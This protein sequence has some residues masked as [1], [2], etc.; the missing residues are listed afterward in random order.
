[1]LL[2]QASRDARRELSDRFGLWARVTGTLSLSAE[3]LE[4]MRQ[5]GEEMGETLVGELLGSAAGAEQL[6]GAVSQ[7]LGD[8]LY[9]GTTGAALVFSATPLDPRQ[10]LRQ[11]EIRLRVP[12]D[13]DAR[14]LVEHSVGTQSVVL[15]GLFRAYLSALHYRLLAI[16]VEEPEVHLFPH[17]ARALVK[18]IRAL[19]VQTLVTT[20]STSVTDLA[21]PRDLLLLRRHGDRTV[22]CAV[23][24]GYLTDDEAKDIRR[25]VRAAGSGFV[26]A[27][28]VLFAEGASEELALPVLAEQLELDL[29]S[30]GVSL[31]TVD[32]SSFRAFAKLLHPQA[33]NI[34]HLMVCDNDQAVRQFVRDLANAGVLPPGVVLHDPQAG[35]AILEAAGYYWWTAGD[36]ESCLLAAG[37]GPLFRQAIAELY[38][39]K[40]LDQ[41]EQQL[42][43][44]QG[45]APADERELIV[46][47]VRQGRV[48]KPKIA[49]RVAEL[50]GEHGCAVPEEVRRLLE[51]LAQVARDQM[52]TSSDG[53]PP[54]EP[55]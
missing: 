6:A 51:R 20:H 49:Q 40:R 1:M 18:S 14:P 54:A 28:A 32:G 41:Y 47:F 22:A 3:Q 19:D 39:A 27:R 13:C 11:I 24:D 16:G 8:V 33:L 34:P 53:N 44:Q 23:P 7:L 17:A 15:F 45:R 35:R 48:S 26:F 37:A 31:V 5:R 25:R 36:F 4:R 38:G 52:E 10:L 50:F 30:L 46:G 29:D 21:D 43:A 42:R 9:G 55:R 2:F 12:G